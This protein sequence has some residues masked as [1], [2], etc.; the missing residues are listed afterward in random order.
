MQVAQR[1]SDIWRTAGGCE[2][3]TRQWKEEEGCVAAEGGRDGL[4]NRVSDSTPL[5]PWDESRSAHRRSA[6]SGNCV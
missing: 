2:G 5:C 3:G 6:A 4:I 1:I